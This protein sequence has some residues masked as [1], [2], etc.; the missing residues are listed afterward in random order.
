MCNGPQKKGTTSGLVSP[1]VVYRVQGHIVIPFS[2]PNTAYDSIVGT[3]NSWVVL[4]GT[5]IISQNKTTMQNSTREIVDA[6]LIIP[7]ET[8]TTTSPCTGCTTGD[9]A[10][11]M[12]R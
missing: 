5:D 1:I 11:G 2:P 4:M 7:G 10:G 12:P 8:N 6:Q 3:E 9:P